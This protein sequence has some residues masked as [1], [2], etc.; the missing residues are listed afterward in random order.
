MH[1]KIATLLAGALLA[2]G[3]TAHA[4]DDEEEKAV[5]YRESVF[6][7]MG[8]NF[9]PM[10]DMMKGEIDFDA[11]EFATRAERVSQLAHMP[12]EGFVEGT[13]D[14]AGSEAKPGIWENWEDFQGKME[15]LQETSAELAEVAQG[16]DKGAIA[17]KFKAVG[18]SCK[19]CHDDYKED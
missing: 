3:A 11:E 8:H 6:H 17:P 7:V 10:G 18:E 4:A 1:R 2:T 16:G 14:V 15:D 9:K 13:A 5:E 12:M 19:A